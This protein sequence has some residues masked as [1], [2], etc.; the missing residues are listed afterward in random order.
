[1][2]KNRMVKGA[3]TALIAI[4][5]LA[6]CGAGEKEDPNGDGD[7]LQIVATFSILY[8]LMNQIGGDKV[9]VHSMVPLGTDPHEYEPLPED[10]QKASNADLLIYNGLNLEGGEDG[11]FFKLVESVGQEDEVI[12]E[13]MEGVEPKYIGSED[14]TERE[15]NPHAFLDPHVGM[16]MAENARDA[17]IAV[18]P[19]NE[20]YYAENAKVYLEELEAIDDLY[21]E[22]IAEIPEENRILVTSERAFQ[23]MTERYGLQE[24]FIWEIDTEENGSPEQ[25]RSLVK[26][27]EENNV[28]ALFVESNVDPRPME[29]VSQETRIEIASEIYSDEL[30]AP[31]SDGEIYTKLL[32]ANIEKIHEGLAK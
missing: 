2:P 29:T 1:M 10:T 4:F 14:G 5:M 9:E 27:I 17:L 12:Y 7:K 28:V 8:D 26:F 21:K 32:R 3:I 15:I 30:G 25:I 16:V 6:A 22:K 31:G 11:W 19:A 23:Y 20:E 24:G 13:L 18:D